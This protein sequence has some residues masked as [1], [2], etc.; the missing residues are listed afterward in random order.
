VRWADL[1][2]LR[3]MV[4]DSWHRSYSPER[5]VGHW[6]Y[7]RRSELE[8]IV[9]YIHQADFIFNGSL[10]YELAILKKY[11]GPFMDDIWSA[12]Q[13][14]PKRH[15]AMIRAR[16]VYDLLQSVYAL[17]D[18]SCVPKKSL[19]REYIGGSDYEY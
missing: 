2:M 19:M 12:Y 8:Y 4:R 5:T 10:P 17:E 1:R 6:H 7:V 14:E 3:R 18:D 16:R 11:L 9:P 13:N 15:D